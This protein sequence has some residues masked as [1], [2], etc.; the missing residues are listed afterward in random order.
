[1]RHGVEDQQRREIVIQP[2]R[3]LPDPTGPPVKTGGLF[4]YA[5]ATIVSCN[6]LTGV[7][8]KAPQ[9]QLSLQ[10]M[11]LFLLAASPMQA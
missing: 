6:C 3:D 4:F 8:R 5:G 7:N 2:D 11:I 10:R 1:M 9:R